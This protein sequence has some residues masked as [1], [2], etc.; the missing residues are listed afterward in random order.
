MDEIINPKIRR[1]QLCVDKIKT[2]EDLKKVLDAMKIRIDTNNS[3]WDNVSDYFCLEVVPK[4][5][6]ELLKKIGWDGIAKLHF[7]E[8]EEQANILLQ[9]LDNSEKI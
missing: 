3:E 7:H 4:G 5:Y 8:I 9:E 6:V 1:Y 2:F